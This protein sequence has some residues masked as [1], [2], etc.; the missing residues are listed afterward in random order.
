MKKNVRTVIFKLKN[1]EYGLPVN[2]VISIERLQH[3]VEV[4]GISE[5]IKGITEIRGIVI[6]LYDLG[7]LL[8]DESIHKNEDTQIILVDINGKTVGLLVDEATDVLDIPNDSIQQIFMDGISKSYLLGIAKM[9][10][11]LITLIDINNLLFNTPLGTDEL[12]TLKQSI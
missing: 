5:S 1:K 10:K 3:I 9:D 8:L 2:Q 11:R 12:D 4:P 7:D 6:P